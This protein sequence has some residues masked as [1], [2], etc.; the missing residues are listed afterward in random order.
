MSKHLRNDPIAFWLAI[1]DLCQHEQ[2]AL[3]PNISYCPDGWNAKQR[4]RADMRTYRKYARIMRYA[5][6]RV[7]QA[8]KSQLKRR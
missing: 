6:E 2:A 8:I 1:I 4:K 7:H 3:L 5:T